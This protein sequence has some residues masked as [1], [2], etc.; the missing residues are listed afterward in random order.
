MEGPNRKKEHWLKAMSMNDPKGSKNLE[1][2]NINMCFRHFH[3]SNI[4]NMMKMN[5]QLN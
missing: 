2:E 3:K 1:N 4:K 5:L